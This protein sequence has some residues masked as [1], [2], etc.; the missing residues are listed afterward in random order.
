[1]LKRGTKLKHKSRLTAI[2]IVSASRVIGSYAYAD[3]ITSQG[4]Y[5][6]V[7]LKIR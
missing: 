3:H 5:I 7:S 4:V 6:I 2:V 1:M